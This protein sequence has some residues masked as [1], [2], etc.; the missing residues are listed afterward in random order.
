MFDWGSG[1]VS[2][3]GQYPEYIFA[4]VV[5]IIALIVLYHFSRGLILVF[6]LFP[7]TASPQ[8]TEDQRLLSYCTLAGNLAICRQIE[9]DPRLSPGVFSDHGRS[10]IWIQA[11]YNAIMDGKDGP[12]WRLISPNKRYSTS[13][14]RP[15]SEN[16]EYECAGQG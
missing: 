3:Y 15:F 11:S 10:E 6:L 12:N 7:L 16:A 1:T 13:T 5:I 8:V 9:N 2:I 14:S 4:A